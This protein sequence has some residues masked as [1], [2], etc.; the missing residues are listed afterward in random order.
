MLQ[1]KLP[2]LVLLISILE[3]IFTVCSYANNSVVLEQQVAAIADKKIFIVNHGWH[4]SLIIP[5]VV[6][7][8]RLPD[9]QERFPNASHLEIGWGDQGFYQA[10]KITLPLLI[11][12]LFWP[13]KSVVHVVDVPQTVETYFSK[14]EIAVICLNKV[15]YADLL[16]FI[17]SSMAKNAKGKLITKQKG[18]YGNSQFYAG[19]GQYH[20]MNTCNKW[21]VKALASAGLNISPQFKLTAS[22]VMRSLSQQQRLTVC[23]SK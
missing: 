21:T 9:L 13:T 15:Q 20:F 12:A 11:K 7:K 6:L 8:S 22:S 19:I 10:K 2:I 5:A 17:E 4:T 16:V 3:P 14:S 1:Y 18:I 23:S